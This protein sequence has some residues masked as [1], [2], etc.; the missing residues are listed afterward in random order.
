MSHRDQ[1]DSPPLYWWYCSF[2]DADKPKGEQF[3]GGCYVGPAPDIAT[4]ITQTHILG[5]NPGGEVEFVRL[6]RRQLDAHVRADDRLRLLTRE[7]I[8]RMTPSETDGF[9]TPFALWIRSRRVA[10]GRSRTR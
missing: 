3:L 4:A 6:T 9:V 10:V 5:I 7:E 2:A 1:I 8:E